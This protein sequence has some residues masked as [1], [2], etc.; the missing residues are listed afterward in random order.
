MRIL[1]VASTVSSRA[2]GE[3]RFV[4]D[5]VAG[6]SRRGHQVHAVAESVEDPAMLEVGPAGSVAARRPLRDNAAQPG[7][8][9]R[10]FAAGAARRI[11]HDVTLSLTRL[12][13]ASV[14]MPIDF[15]AAAWTRHV[16][17]Q[18]GPIR[19][20]MKVPRHWTLP[21]SL[22]AEARAPR[23]LAP[24]GAVQRLLVFGRHAAVDAARLMPHLAGRIMDA[25]FAS[26]LERPTPAAAASLRRRTREALGLAAESRVVLA[27]LPWS[28]ASSD[29]DLLAFLGGASMLGS[30]SPALLILARDALAV[31]AAAVRLDGL[32]ESRIRILGRTAHIDAA[33]AAADAVAVPLA[34]PAGPFRSGSMGRMVADALRWGRPVLVLPGAPG[35]ELIHTDAP[36]HE[37]PGLAVRAPTTE[38][39]SDA[40]ARV[41]DDAW[42]A[43]AG[44][45]AASAGATLDLDRQVDRIIEALEYVVSPGAGSGFARAPATR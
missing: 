15:G 4:A 1:L 40:L 19:L 14:W 37:R 20:L 25:G 44:A 5:V 24:T 3:G 12:V 13:P 39:W 22:A 18:G 43:S 6:L 27:S 33:L 2:W 11:G 29:P 45:A 21:A 30:R 17:R 9:L 28:L 42:L 16:R 34:P 10:R 35:M 26:R 32:A 41:A 8:A 38:A 23:I 36:E 7:G 31:H